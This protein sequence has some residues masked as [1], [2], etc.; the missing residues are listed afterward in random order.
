MG[1]DTPIEKNSIRTLFTEN[2]SKKARLE[3]SIVE[4]ETA[5]NKIQIGTGASNS[6]RGP[7]QSVSE[8]DELPL[9]ACL[10]Q[11]SSE[12]SILQLSQDEVSC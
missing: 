6:T 12:E 8:A 7:A 10:T 9:D 11:D 4:N 1:K 2:P 3:E 5:M